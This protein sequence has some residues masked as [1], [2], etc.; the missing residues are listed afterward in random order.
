MPGSAA[1]RAFA[2]G[3]QQI[4]GSTPTADATIQGHG[5][6]HQ[7]GRATIVNRPAFTRPAATGIIKV[8]R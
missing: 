2:I 8:N 1:V 3:H 4:P 7:S 6:I 5:I